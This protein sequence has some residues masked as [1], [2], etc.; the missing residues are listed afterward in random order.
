[1]ESDR[2]DNVDDP[3]PRLLN[4]RATVWFECVVCVCRKTVFVKLFMAGVLEGKD[5]EKY[6][7]A[8]NLQLVATSILFGLR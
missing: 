4:P 8:P 7:N 5:M 3:S 1:M 2:V 6:I